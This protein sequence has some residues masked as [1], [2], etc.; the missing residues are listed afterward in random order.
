MLGLG[1]CRRWLTTTPNVI[2]FAVVIELLVAVL[3]VAMYLLQPHLA[4]PTLVLT[5]YIVVSVYLSNVSKI[6]QQLFTRLLLDDDWQLGRANTFNEILYNLSWIAAVPLGAWSVNAWSLTGLFWMNS[7]VSLVLAAVLVL[8]F[9][10]L[11]N[12][13][14]AELSVDALAASKPEK[15]RLLELIR[16]EYKGV[17][18]WN[19]LRNMTSSFMS[20]SMIPLILATHGL[21]DL[22][23]ISLVGNLGIVLAIY[24]PLPF[25]EH[26]PARLLVFGQLLMSLA[27]LSMMLPW[28][29]SMCFAFFAFLYGIITTNSLEAFILQKRSTERDRGALFSSREQMAILGRTSGYVFSALLPWLFMGVITEPNALAIAIMGSVTM[30]IAAY[31]VLQAFSRRESV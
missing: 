13:A 7:M 9:W 6:T 30:L 23:W 24:R 28:L 18:F 12:R 27:M 20:A 15:G 21:S 17:F 8:L 16:K 19:Y 31:K 22:I 10:S 26:N 2:R 14:K 11:H 4:Q 5:L 3:G 29:L 25:D 1:F